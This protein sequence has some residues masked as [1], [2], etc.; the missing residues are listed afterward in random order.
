MNDGAG[1]RNKA[2]IQLAAPRGLAVSVVG[3][4]EDEAPDYTPLVLRVR[5]VEFKR[6][7]WSLTGVSHSIESA[8]G[9][10]L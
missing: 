10:R 4:T 5:F 2:W 1:R 7:D 9:D 3:V 6:R 8:F